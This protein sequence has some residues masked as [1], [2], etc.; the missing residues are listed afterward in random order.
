MPDAA[1]KLQVQDAMFSYPGLPKSAENIQIDVEGYYYG[2]QMDN[3]TL[4]VNRF[5]VDL[6]GNPVDLT[7]NIK[8]PESDMMVNGNLKCNLDLATVKDVI[9]LDNTTITGKINA[10]IDMM[11]YMSYIEKEEYE[12]FKADGNLTITDFHYS[13]PDLPKEL[14]I[15]ETSVF[16]SPKYSEIK[17]FN[18]VM[19][20]SDFRLSGRVENYIPYLFK[21]KTIKGDFIF[22]SGVLDLNEFLAESEET[23]PEESDTVPLSVV[24]VPGNIDFKL[25]SRIDKLYYDKLELDNTVGII[26]IKDSRV[27]LENLKTQTLDGSLQ[28]NG[29]Y[30][31][32]DIAN[33][34]VDLG[35]QAVNI[36]IPMAYEALDL[37]QQ[38]APIAK[39]AQGKVSIG[40]NFSS[41]LDET[42][43]PRLNSVTGKGNLEASTIGL[44]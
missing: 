25:V 6:G 11:G 21:D 31:T 26:K 10:A 2:V 39:K 36:D 24:K 32:K 18:A 37:L 12:K 41:F 40:F 29:E 28:L 42:M 3:S 34:A 8:T 16:F 5:H 43:M 22:T 38:F 35:I 1:I 30:N 44:K 33:P 14:K 20:K 19:G 4:D 27:I 17:S 15:I 23:V 13:S 7:L 9:P